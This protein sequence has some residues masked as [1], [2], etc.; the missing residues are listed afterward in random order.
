[1]QDQDDDWYVL[2]PWDSDGAELPDG[3]GIIIAL[4]VSII[5]WG[6]LFWIL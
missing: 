4:V 5:F 2:D 1:M 6:V 3:S